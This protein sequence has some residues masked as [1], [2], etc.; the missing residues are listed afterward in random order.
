MAYFNLLLLFSHACWTHHSGMMNM[1]YP[2]ISYDDLKKVINDGNSSNVTE[3]CVFNI[4]F[5]MSKIRAEICI[6]IV[7]LCFTV[8]VSSTEL[9]KM[10]LTSD[11]LSSSVVVHYKINDQR[12]KQFILCLFDL[13]VPIHSHLQSWPFYI[14]RQRMHISTMYEH[15]IRMRHLSQE[16]LLL[17][18]TQ[19]EF[20]CMKALLLFSISKYCP[21]YWTSKQTSGA[22]VE[23]AK[24]ES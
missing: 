22:A 12:V 20:L 17:Q 3:L 5:Q 19:E 2:I 10:D 1:K 14:C 11:I 8:T 23:R 18:I 9:I 13:K 21:V 15:C 16:L 7:I 4:S 24:S 6:V